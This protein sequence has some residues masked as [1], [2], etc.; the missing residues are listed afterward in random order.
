MMEIDN[1]KIEIAE[2]KDHGL[3]EYTDNPFISAL[4]LLKDLQS[5]LKDMIVPPSFDEREL[6]LDWH[7]R[8]HALQRLTHQFFQPRVQH[9]VLEQ[10]LSVLIRQGYIGRNP[11]TAAFKK[12]LNNGY[13][14]IV[15]KDINLTVRREVESTAVGF[16]IIGLS[17][18]GKTKAVQKCLETYPKA[19]FHPELHVIQIPWLKLECPRNGSL[20]ELC[21]NFFR[22]VDSRIGTQYFNT[23]CK[24]RVSVDSLIAE[25]AQIANLHAIGVLV[26]DEIQHLSKKRS[27][28]EEAMLDFF[29]TLTNSIGV[30]VVF[31][32]TP[33]ARNLFATDFKMA[34]RTT[35]LGNVLWDRIPQ[36][37]EWNRLVSYIWRYQWLRSKGN[38]TQQ[39]T[40]ALYDLSQGVIDILVKLYVLSQWRAMILGKEILTVELI[41][42]VYEDDLQPVHK[43]LQALRSGNPQEIV[44]YGD[45]VMPEVEAKLLQALEQQKY[46]TNDIEH[47]ISPPDNDK[48]N[49]IMAA[50]E[51]LGINRDIAVPL[52]EAALKED[53]NLDTMQVVHRMLNL[54]HSTPTP[55]KVKNPSKKPKVSLWD[56]L[57]END[58]RY[59]YSQRG[60]STMHEALKTAGIIAAVSDCLKVS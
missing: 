12:H 36:D 3:P 42:K 31:V 19:I 11:A 7:Q 6:N 58:I 28:G 52:I 25:M 22:A 20:T 8:I 43:M 27:G 55:P 15:N 39:I 29:V 4:P 50:A 35:G 30:P 9:G 59:I 47:P 33:K 1:N 54:L 49:T 21:Y 56:Q 13:D 45:L 17:G 37:D 24:P 40:D 16:S 60:N 34:K 57:P 44:K 10:K 26:I 51:L 32:G 23:Y 2:Y 5:I 41:K 14:R 53:P 46:F 48:L 38:L 18:C